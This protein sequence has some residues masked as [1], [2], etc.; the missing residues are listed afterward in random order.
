MSPRPRGTFRVIGAGWRVF[1]PVVV[2]VAVIQT[3]LVVTDPQPTPSPVFAALALGSLAAALVA[4]W[5]IGNAAVS[6]AGGGTV[7]GPFRRPATLLWLLVL[8]VAAAAAAIWFLPA[9][10]VV[11]FLA[12]LLLPPLADGAG[13]PLRRIL[14]SVRRRPVGYLLA[15]LLFAVLIVLGWVIALLCGFFLAWPLSAAGAW[16]WFGIA[17]VILLARLAVLHR[18]T[19]PAVG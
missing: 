12:A 2:A 10:P 4:T 17:T 16:L 6:A 5:L 15:L 1:V 7:T 3:L 8:A 14:Q 19:H 11:L 9:F 13:D 18:R